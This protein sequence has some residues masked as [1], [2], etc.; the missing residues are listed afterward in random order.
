MRRRPGGINGGPSSGGR[1]DACASR[2]RRVDPSGPAGSSR[3]TVPSSI[4][5]STARPVSSFVIDAQRSTTP[6]APYAPSS[7]PARTTPAAAVRAPHS[8]TARSAFT[9]GDTRAMDR[10]LVPAVSPFAATVGYSRAVR[11]GRHVHVAG[12][13]PIYP[14]GVDT[15]ADPYAQARRALEIVAAALAEVGAA[16]AHVVRTRVYLVD[17]ADWEAVGRAHGEM[18]A[19]VRPVTSFVVVAGLLDPRWLVEIEAEALLPG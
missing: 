4:A 18:F 9:A 3:S 13:A 10:R 5:T 8:S 17:A 7:V 12:T 11:D 14:E 16:P 15:P 2:C 1:P 6:G 19:D